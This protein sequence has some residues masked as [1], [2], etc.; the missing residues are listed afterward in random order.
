MAIKGKLFG[1]IHAA[2][3]MPP[4]T[5]TALPGYSAWHARQ[6]ARSY[7]ASRGRGRIAA[8]LYDALHCDM[9]LAA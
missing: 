6:M 8:M 4:R 2:M 9:P 7:E 3:R 1:S 5:A